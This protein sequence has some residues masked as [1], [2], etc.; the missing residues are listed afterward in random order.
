MEE[1]ASKRKRERETEYRVDVPMK[2]T[3]GTTDNSIHCFVVLCYSL[4]A[5]AKLLQWKLSEI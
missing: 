3:I 4:M 2:V 1:G 5:G